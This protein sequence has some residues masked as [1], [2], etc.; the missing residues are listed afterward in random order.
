MQHL[1]RYIWDKVLKNGPSK[2]CERQPLKKM[3]MVYLGRPYQFKFFKGCL[4]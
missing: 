2:I 3:D 1:H 4:P